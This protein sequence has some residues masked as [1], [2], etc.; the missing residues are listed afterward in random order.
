MTV[1]RDRADAGRVLAGMLRQHGIERPLVLGIPR[2]G[3]IVGE[4]IARE[5]G[6]EL[7]VVVARKL[8]APAQPELAIGAVTA[9]GTAWVDEGLA[10]LCDADQAYL[11]REIAEQ[12]RE[13]QRREEAFG[14][15]RN[16]DLRG[17]TVLVV[18]DGLATGATARAALRSVKQA[19]AARA[20][21][22]VPV[23]P[24]HTAREME[25][26]ADEVIAATIDSDF[27][28][29]GQFYVDFRPVTDDEVRAALG[30][31]AEVGGI[32]RSDVRI[33][34]GEIDLAAR[35]AR[36]AGDGPYPCV[37]FVHGLG[38]DKDSP[39]NVP[40]AER[41]LDLGIATL[42]FDLNGHGESPED[43][44][45]RAAYPIDLAAA[46]AWTVTEPSIDHHAVGVSGSSIGGTVALEAVHDGKLKPRT[47][48]LRAPPVEPDA[49]EGLPMTVLVIVG[50]LDPLRTD[51]EYAAA[52]TDAAAVSVVPG[53]GHLFEEPGALDEALSRTTRWF[54]EW[55][56]PDGNR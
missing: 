14:A 53:A 9:D 27:Y 29:I 32:E 47:M 17:R 23:A 44:R 11:D 21:L 46:Y 34:R 22:A 12:T 1:Y 10:R 2:G 13:A 55:L 6:G 40:I 41:L 19:G 48:V 52:R 5:L 16:R 51:I 35:F 18:D 36:P 28:A 20:V 43:A 31:I 42:R 7:G 39:R 45:G 37:I 38:S 25:S 49:F 33:R 30:N 24:P 4:E 54:Q 26:E 3:V 15:E 56:S 8:G 50:E